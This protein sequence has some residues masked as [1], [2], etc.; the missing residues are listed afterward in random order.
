MKVSLRRAV[1]ALAVACVIGFA[2]AALASAGPAPAAASNFGAGSLI[3]PMDTDT[4]GNHASFNQ[5]AGMWKSYGLLYRLL[6]NG[7]PVHWGILE[8]KTATTTADFTVGS[9]KDARTGTALGSWS[10][11]GGPFIID[12]ADAAV[13]LPLIQSWWAANGN[14]PNVHEALTGFGADVNV[15]LR[16]A[17]RIA[18]EE[19]NASIA[20]AY[21]NAAGIPDSAGNEWTKNSPS[22]L[23][24]TAIANG[25]LFT[26]GSVC[27]QRKF[28]TFVTPHNGGYS[29]S[30]SDPSSLGT[31]AYAQLDT[32][33]NQGGGWTAL[34]HS[35]LSNE[36]AIQDLTVNGNT[37]VKSLFATSLPGGKPGGF[38]TS[39]GFDTISNS[40]G[41]GTWRV[42]PA[43]AGLPV[44]QSVPTAVAQTLP[45]GAVQT[46]PATGTGAPSYWPGTERVGYFDA[47]VDQDNILSGTYH[48]GT[49][50][51]KLTYIGGH[52]FSTAV[53]YSG[54]A[55]APYLRAFYNSL[56]FNGSA[57]A[58]LDMTLSPPTFPQNGKGLLTA[59]IANSGGSVAT[60]VDNVSVQLA[61][62]FHYVPGSGSPVEPVV[63][64][65]TLTWPAGLGDVAGGATAVTFKVSVDT[66]ALTTQ[67][68][69]NFGKFHATYGDVF[70]EAFTADVCRDITISAPQHP[71][72][73]IVKSSDTSAST[74][75][76]DVV[77]FGFAVTNTGDVTITSFVVTD[78]LPGLSAISCPV[79]SLAVGASTACSATYT[80]KQSDVDTGVLAN[81]AVVNG[82]TETAGPVTDDDSLSSPLTQHPAIHI[83]KSSNATG[84]TKVGD[85]VAFSFA[86]TN[87]GDVTITSFV[88]TDPLPGLSAI[89]CPVSSLAVGASTACTATYTVKQ[90][91]V[92]AGVLANKAVVDGTTESAGPVTD[93]DTLTKPLAQ[94]PDIGIV[95]SAD[96]TGFAADGVLVTYTYTV[97]NSGNVTLDP[98]NVTDPMPGLSA[99]NCTATKLLP[100]KSL[101]CTA[102]YTT[103]QADVDSGKVE[104][105]GTA[106]G[107]PP[108][109]A[110]VTDTSSLSIPANQSPALSL[111]KHG[112]LDMT[113]VPPANLPNVGDEINYTLT[114]TNTGN[115]T[116][117]NVVIT[118]PKLGALTC[119]PPQ[120]VTLAPTATLTCAAS[121]TLTQ[122]D[123]DRGEVKNTA[124]VD[125]DQTPPSDSTETVPIPASPELSVAKTADAPQ[126][127]VGE[128]IGFTVTVFNTGL[129]AA[130]DVVLADTLP[131][132]SGLSW[133][134]A[135][136]GTGW[137]APCTIT[138]GVLSCGPVTVPAETAEATSTFT[139]HVTSTTSAA[140]GGMCPEGGAVDNTASVTGSNAEPDTASASTCVQ[141]VADLAITKLGS[142]DPLTLGDGNI[143]WTM[144]VTNSG[145]SEDANVTVTDPLPGGNTYVS[146]TAT[147]GSCTGVAG[148]VN[149]AIGT[150]AADETVVI[151]LVTKP[152]I[153]GNQVNNAIV[154]G[155]LPETNTANN[156][157]SAAVLVV[158]PFEPP[159]YCVAVAKVQPKQLYVDRK[160]KLT[161]HLRQHGKAVAGVHVRVKGP[162]INIVTRHSN[163]NGVIK[164]TLKPKKAGV[165]VFV[166]LASKSCNTARIGITGVF[167][168]PVTG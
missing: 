30:L 61:A 55:E 123:L 7:V 34:C 27:L 124:T 89:G 105:T 152:S 11:A 24:E 57:V 66:S 40:T 38:L 165:L 102:T 125:S 100:G 129:A 163:V 1:W 60:N 36:N 68:L 58:K 94:S 104:N 118:D 28:D 122:A 164:L 168:P 153:T 12:S 54:N 157:A 86:V 6:E 140:T 51:G 83:V 29:Y 156:Q 110:N 43:S 49:G 158:G 25:G 117:T 97:T 120:P 92:D 63:N 143:T 85:V 114:A 74:K 121:Y 134:I 112:V 56:F 20:I 142:P 73:Q 76:G 128:S 160:V 2:S 65:Q 166:P 154:S 87:T 4:T 44:A 32:F 126:Q 115:V 88:V 53:P 3:I 116:L 130:Q 151:T 96:K 22:I 72:I 14:Q 127:Q 81:T 145:P 99:L 16:S 109:G 95:K 146:A 67:G 147:K 137:G 136:Q 35:I 80:V 62:P 135:S 103:T 75:A 150:M 15:T 161:L 18:N 47:A 77:T 149:C 141:S 106:S 91:D 31:R 111:E 101:T 155:D 64:G 9:V 69:T 8:G 59:T 48:D 133:S 13:A 50:L 148:V 5:N 90:S 139:V 82:E 21:Y 33:V 71:G 39:S 23:D 46:W 70:G 52:S 159:T 84:S 108:V 19:V 144:T 93:D 42:N 45:G 113:V 107:K 162:K 167:T 10:Y 131:A 138:A 119:R 17:P 79:S 26:Q 98:V 132:T 78:P 41:G 37:A